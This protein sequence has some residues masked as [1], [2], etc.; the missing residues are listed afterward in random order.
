MANAITCS[1]SVLVVFMRQTVS[2][3]V[4]LCSLVANIF[5]SRCYCPCGINSFLTVT[6]FVFGIEESNVSGVVSSIFCNISN[7]FLVTTVANRSSDVCICGIASGLVS[8]ITVISV[9]FW[10]F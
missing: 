1:F 9:G 4:L 3:K 5:A 2:T 10:T 8:D 7:L 6:S